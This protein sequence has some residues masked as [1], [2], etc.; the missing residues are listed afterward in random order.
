MSVC[1]PVVYSCGSVH[2]M[3]F[4]VRHLNNIQDSLW[5]WVLWLDYFPSVSL[6]IEETCCRNDEFHIK[7]GK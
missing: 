7:R 6:P 3:W 5:Q 2:M 4:C 1:G